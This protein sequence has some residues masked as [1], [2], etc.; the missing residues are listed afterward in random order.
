MSILV[1]KDLEQHAQDA[2]AASASNNSAFRRFKSRCQK[3]AGISAGPV[4]RGRNAGCIP[5]YHWGLSGDS[6]PEVPR[7][8]FGLG[9]ATEHRSAA[10]SEVQ[11]RSSRVRSR[12]E[13]SNVLGVVA[14]NVGLL[15]NR[16]LGHRCIYNVARACF[17][18]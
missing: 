6:S 8:Y 12:E 5:R 15:P 7:P 13:S 9:S 1:P 14:D 11:D 4:A 18:E 16:K 3:K 2:V 17:A 10:L